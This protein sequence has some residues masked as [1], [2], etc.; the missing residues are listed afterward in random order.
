MGNFRHHTQASMD[1]LSGQQGH[2]GPPS[3]SSI[4]WLGPTSSLGFPGGLVVKNP[5]ANAGDTGDMSWTSGLGRSS[6]GGHGNLL[7]YFCVRNPHGQRSLAGYSP[8]GCKESDTTEH[9]HTHTHSLPFPP[10]CELRAE[11]GVRWNSLDP[12]PH[13]VQPGGIGL[14]LRN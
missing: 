7:Q 1:A 8:W 2:P 14:S 6:G 13:D 11:P 4:A 10:Q 12:C 3:E 5:P 9:T